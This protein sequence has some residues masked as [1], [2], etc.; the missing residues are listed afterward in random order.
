MILQQQQQQIGRNLQQM[1]Q[2]L[3]QLDEQEA[4]QGRRNAEVAQA[5]R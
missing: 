3:E 1:Q 2:Q 4:A 5:R